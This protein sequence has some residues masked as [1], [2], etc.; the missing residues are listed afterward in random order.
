[1]GRGRRSGR[2]RPDEPHRRCVACRKRRPQPEL[3]RFAVQEGRVVPD[4]DRSL[5]GRGAWL[6]RA[7]AC[8]R[9]LKGGQLSRALKGRAVEPTTQEI[10][11]WASP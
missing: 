3:F 9:A 1:V 2:V 7:E 11:Q 10:L 6:C 5:P 4:R 8:A